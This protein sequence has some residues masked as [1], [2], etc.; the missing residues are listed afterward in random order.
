ME[1]TVDIERDL[2]RIAEQ[3]R[4][5]C[6]PRFDAE[7]AWELGARLKVLAEKRKAAL[8]IE[9]R[10]LGQTSFFF[11]MPGT[12]PINADWARRKRNAVELMQKSSYAIGLG[13]QRDGSDL[14]SKLG[15]PTRDYAS[16]GGGFPIRADGVGCIGVVTV[17]GLPQRE[18]HGLVVEALAAM[19]DLPLEELA[20]D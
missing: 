14:E 13:L 6:F 10:L 9:I 1:T 17:S 4:R 8:C 7:S 5:L 12:T 11:A 15:L 18:D 3:E 20:L 16:H 2:A 19:L